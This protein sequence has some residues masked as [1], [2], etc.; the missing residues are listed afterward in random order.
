MMNSKMTNKNLIHPA[1]KKVKFSPSV[2]GNKAAMDAYELPDAVSVNVKDLFPNMPEPIYA[3]DGDD[4]SLV[5]KATRKAMEKVDLSSIKPGD[6]VN[7]LSCEHGFL[8]MGGKPYVEMIRTMKKVVEERTG[9]YNIRVKLVMFQTPR[10]GTEVID[11]YRLNEEIGDVEGVSSFEKGVAIDTRIGT[12][13]GLENVFNADKI[14]LAYYDDPR[15]VYCHRYYRK[16]FKA[17]TMDLMRLET[18]ALYHWGY[19]NA[20]GHMAAAAIVPT[21]VYD[22]DFV[23]SKWVGACL[24]HSTPNGLTGIDAD[25]CLYNLDDRL[26]E[27]VLKYYPYMSHLLQNSKDFFM[28]LDGERWPYYTHG[29]GI[30]NGVCMSADDPYDLSLAYNDEHYYTPGARFKPDGYKGLILNQTWYGCTFW[31]SAALV[32]Y[33]IVGDEMENLF[34]YDRQN[35]FMLDIPTTNKAA[36]LPEA[37]KLIKKMTGTD[38]YFI[39][40]GSYGYINCSRSAAED[41]FERSPKIKESVDKELYPMYMAQRNLTIPDYMK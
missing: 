12:V 27:T 7:I 11:F 2:Y 16:S 24:L 17:F 40:D 15:E 9:A 13:Y 35:K 28:I 4:L 14:I 26:C 36:T 30:I 3:H 39:F 32:P 6:S 21:S 5:E 20:I 1:R 22:S 18:R 31:Q 33:V 34:K 23:Q 37:V 10:E 8:I 41:L 19:G 38:R 25:N 29:A